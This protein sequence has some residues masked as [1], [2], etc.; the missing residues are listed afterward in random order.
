[1]VRDEPPTVTVV[2]VESPK[3][4]DLA[5]LSR[6]FESVSMRARPA[7]RMSA[8]IAG[9]TDVY[10]AYDGKTLVG[11]G[12]MVSDS[13]FYGSIWDM[14]VEPSMQHHGIG[15]KILDE[16]LRCAHAKGLVI[17]GLFTASH[18]REFY[19]RYGFEFHPDIH[20]MTS[21]MTNLPK[22]TGK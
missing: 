7:D 6:L 22:S 3:D 18:N 10:A 14:A 21:F 1:M 15:A 4:I 11:F 13:A 5:A 2:R 17:L 16:L 19:E 8:T 20:A 12:R 9:S